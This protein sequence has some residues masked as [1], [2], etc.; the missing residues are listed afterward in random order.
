MESNDILTTIAEVA[1]AIA[2][3]SSIIVA[4]S[5]RPIGEWSPVERFNF[6]A[7]LQ[8]AAVVV[9]FS[10]IPLVIHRFLSFDVAW[11]VALLLYGVVHLADVSTFLFRF[12]EHLPTVPKITS[13]IGFSIAVSQLVIG[14]FGTINLVELI[15]L[16]SLLWQLGISFMGFALLI[17]GTRS[18]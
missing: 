17:Y 11:R 18:R 16:V 4:L 2:G 13:V 5:P 14:V 12:P 3:F 15:Y 8:V 6:R 9:F 1:I 7:L 10:L